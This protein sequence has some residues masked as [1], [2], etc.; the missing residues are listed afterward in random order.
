MKFSLPRFSIA[1]HTH[2]TIINRSYKKLMLQT[3]KFVSVKFKRTVAAFS[4]AAFSVSTVSVSTVSVATASAFF[5][6]GVR[7]QTKTNGDS[8][9]AT[10]QKFYQALLERRL[11]DALMLTNLRAAVEPLSAQE[12]QEF[13][14]DL[15]PFAEQARDVAATGEQTSGNLA[16]VFVKGVDPKTNLPKL[17][18]VKLR[19]ES[20][21]WTILL[22]DAE[23]EAAVRRE[24]KNYLPKMRIEA[25]HSEIELTLQDLITAQL[26][27]SLKNNGVYADLQTLAAERLLPAEVLQPA[28]IGYNFRMQLAAD[29]KRYTVNAEPVAYGKTGKLSF[30]LESSTDKNGGPRIQNA[31]KAGAPIAVKK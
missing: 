16:S 22:G 9:T 23:T 1:L 15:E 6:V 24:G 18:E 19:Q 31:D 26:A 11:R 20:G 10:V 5:T 8:P 27:Y 25:R 7:A 30:L 2:K 28:V 12:M 17:D 3:F 21:A 13:N 29:K 14:Q 4:L